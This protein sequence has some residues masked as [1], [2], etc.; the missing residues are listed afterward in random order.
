MSSS[1]ERSGDLS[2]IDGKSDDQKFVE[3]LRGM[4]R[5][6]N[7]DALKIHTRAFA[8]NSVFLLTA[9]SNRL[10]TKENQQKGS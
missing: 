9:S 6:P 3:E 4:R 2:F 1:S 7:E 5:A 8:A 10:P